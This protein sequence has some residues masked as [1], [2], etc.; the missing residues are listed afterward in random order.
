MRLKQRL[1]DPNQGSMRASCRP[2]S[3]LHRGWVGSATHLQVQVRCVSCVHACMHSCGSACACTVCMRA[4]V[5]QCMHVRFCECM[6]A[7]V[8]AYARCDRHPALACVA[9]MK[10]LL[11]HT[12][13]HAGA[14]ALPLPAPPRAPPAAPAATI[15]AAAAATGA[16]PPPFKHLNRAGTRMRGRCKP[17]PGA[18]RTRSCNGAVAGPDQPRHVVLHQQG[19]HHSASH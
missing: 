17:H 2:V 14:Q 1:C 10:E 11:R 13:T 4:C 3:V 16:E 9:G 6:C 7:C 12:C 18:G 15:H 8:R 5:L 19:A